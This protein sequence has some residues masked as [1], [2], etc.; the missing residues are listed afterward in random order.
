MVSDLD[1]PDLDITTLTETKFVPDHFVF[2]FAGFLKDPDDDPKLSK[3]FDSLQSVRCIFI[4][5]NPF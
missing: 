5:L 2:T 3:L 1:V 4:L